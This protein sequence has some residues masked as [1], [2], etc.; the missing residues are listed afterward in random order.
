MAI[1]PGNRTRGPSGHRTRP[2]ARKTVSRGPPPHQILAEEHH[3]SIRVPGI[4]RWPGKVQ[5]NTVAE[6]LAWAEQHPELAPN[7]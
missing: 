6:Y 1:D 5:P 7:G 2:P 3:E 4:L